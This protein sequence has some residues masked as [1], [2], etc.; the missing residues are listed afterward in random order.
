MGVKAVSGLLVALQKGGERFFYCHL[1]VFLAVVL[2]LFSLVGPAFFWPAFVW[3]FLLFLH[4]VF[5]RSR[6]IDDEWAQRRA[7][8]IAEYAYDFSHVQDLK[9]RYG[10]G[11]KSKGRQDT[12]QDDK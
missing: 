9:D 6:Q 12:R 5:I 10:E 1:V 11:S 8:E 4:F 2:I 7:E 3:A